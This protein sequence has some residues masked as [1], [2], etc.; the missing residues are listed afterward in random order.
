MHIC[1]HFHLLLPRKIIQIDTYGNQALGVLD[2]T[3]DNTGLYA[4]ACE[5]VGKQM[6]V[7]VVNLWRLMLSQPNWQEFLLSDGLHFTPAGQLFVLKHVVA[8]LPVDA[9]VD[10]L[11]L[12]FPLGQQMSER[13]PAHSIASHAEK[14]PVIIKGTQW[15]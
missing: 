14:H 15:L 4:A 10:T 1:I 2:R 12:D 6:G 5:T 8:A 13:D 7:P 11:A 3:A 9:Q